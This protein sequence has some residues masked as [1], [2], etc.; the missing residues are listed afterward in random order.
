MGFEEY[1]EG[2][3]DVH[4]WARKAKG[5][6]AHPRNARYFSTDATLLPA[7]QKG[8]ILDAFDAASRAEINLWEQANRVPL[9][10]PENPGAG[11]EWA[12]CTGEQLILAWVA[13]KYTSADMLKD[14]QMLQTCNMTKPFKNFI[15]ELQIKMLKCGTE[16]K[17]MIDV[18]IRAAP[19]RLPAAF[20]EGRE[21]LQEHLINAQLKGL[22]T[23]VP[24]LLKTAV[25]YEQELQLKAE[26]LGLP[27]Y[28]VPNEHRMGM[29][30]EV[31]AVTQG[32]DGPDTLTMGHI[33]KLIAKTVEETVDKK[34]AASEEKL[35]TRLTQVE[36]KL[37][38]NISDMMEVLMDVRSNLK[39]P[40][41]L[42]LTAP[43]GPAAYAPHQRRQAAPS[44]TC[45]RCGERGHWSSQCRAEN[46]RTI[47][48]AQQSAP[49]RFSQQP[50]GRQHPVN[51][52]QVALTGLEC[53]NCGCRD[54][55]ARFCPRPV[56][57]ELASALVNYL[58]Y[59]D[60][61]SRGSGI[62]DAI[63]EQ[64][65]ECTEVAQE[66]LVNALNS[67]VIGPDNLPV[68]DD[69]KIG[70][71]PRK[72][73]REWE[74]LS[75][76][77]LQSGESPEHCSHDRPDLTQ[78]MHQIEDAIVNRRR[79]A[80]MNQSRQHCF[81]SEFSR[82]DPVLAVQIQQSR[83]DAAITRAL[84]SSP[85]P[86][87][88]VILK[89]GSPVVKTVSQVARVQVAA[90]ESQATGQAECR[91]AYDDFHDIIDLSETLNDELYNVVEY[92]LTGCVE[93]T[94]HD[95][96]DLYGILNEEFEH[97]INDD[98]DDDDEIIN[99]SVLDNDDDNDDEIINESILIS[100]TKPG[101]LPVEYTGAPTQG[102]VSD[103]PPDRL[104]HPET[105]RSCHTAGRQ[106]QSA[107]S[108]SKHVGVVTGLPRLGSGSLEF[109]RQARSE[110]SSLGPTGQ[111][112]MAYATG[113]A[114]D[115]DRSTLAF[116]DCVAGLTST[117]HSDG[118]M[119]DSESRALELLGCG[120]LVADGGFGEATDEA[121]DSHSDQPRTLSGVDNIAKIHD[122][123]LN[124]ISN[125][126]PEDLVSVTVIS[127][128]DRNECS[129]E[130]NTSI[131]DVWF[132]IEDY[133][134]WSRGV[135]SEPHG[136]ST[137]PALLEQPTQTRPRRNERW[138]NQGL[139]CHQQSVDSNGNLIRQCKRSQSVNDWFATRPGR[140]TIRGIG[141]GRASRGLSMPTVCG[142]EQSVKLLARLPGVTRKVFRLSGWT[143]EI[144]CRYDDV[145]PAVAAAL[146]IVMGWAVSAMALAAV[147]QFMNRRSAM[148]RIALVAV[149]AIAS[150]AIGIDSILAIDGW[151][152]LN[153]IP[154]MV[155][156]GFT[157]IMAIGAQWVLLLGRELRDWCTARRECYIAQ[158]RDFHAL[159]VEV[160]VLDDKNGVE[161]VVTAV[162]DTG[163]SVTIIPTGYIART[164]SRVGLLPHAP[165]PPVM[166][167]ASGD[168]L[169]D[170]PGA[171]H[172]R[173]R[174]KGCDKVFDCEPWVASNQSVP[175]LLGIDWL[176]ESGAVIDTKRSTMTIDG[177]V[178]PLKAEC[179]TRH[180]VNMTGPVNNVGTDTDSCDSQCY[181][182]R[183]QKDVTVKPGSFAQIRLDINTPVAQLNCLQTMLVESCVDTTIPVLPPDHIEDSEQYEMP[184]DEMPE[185][186]LAHPRLNVGSDVAYIVT[187]V[188]NVTDKPMVIRKGQ[189]LAES[190]TVDPEYIAHMGQGATKQDM[191]NAQSWVNEPTALDAEDWR[192]ACIDYKQIIEKVRLDS[193]PQADRWIE[194]QS[195]TMKFGDDA[196][197]W[198][199]DQFPYLLY[200]FREIAATNAK[201][202]LALVGVQHEFVFTTEPKPYKMK[203]RRRS[204]AQEKAEK[205]QTIIL[206]KNQMI[207]PAVSPFAAEIVLTPK[208][209]GTL[210]YAVDFRMLNE[211]TE[212]D[213]MPL[214][215]PDDVLDRI[216]IA[217]GLAAASANKKGKTDSP[218]VL[219][220][221]FDCASAFWSCIIRECDR[222]YTAF[223]TSLGLMEWIRMPFG[224]KNSMSTY[225]RAMQY[226]LRPPLFPADSAGDVES[227]TKAGERVDVLCETYVDDCT[228]VAETGDAEWSEHMAALCTVFKRF[229]KYKVSI[230]LSKSLWGTTELVMVGYKYI[231]G[232]GIATSDEKIAA[233]MAMEHPR[234]VGEIKTF[235][236]KTGYYRRFIQ[237][238]AAIARPMKQLEVRYKTPTTN[239]E[240]EWVADP[241]YQRSFEAIRSAMANAP[242][243]RSPDFTKPFMV[244][245][246]CSAYAMGA[247]LCQLDEE[248]VEH[249]VCYASCTLS[250]AQVKYGITDREG[251]AVT[252][253][254]RLWRHYL[255][256]NQGGAVVLTD[257]SA[258]TSLM[259]KSDFTNQRMARYAVDLS[260]FDLTICH[261]AG[262]IHHAPDAL[263]R[264]KMCTDPVEIKRRVIEAWN[265][266]TDMALY[267]DL[268]LGSAGEHFQDSL[269]YNR[270]VS[271]AQLAMQVNQAVIE[272]DEVPEG[273]T[274]VRQVLVALE[275][276]KSQLRTPIVDEFGSHAASMYD[277]IL[278]VETEQPGLDK[279]T[280]TQIKQEQKGD[281]WCRHMY[282]YLSQQ[283]L[284]I[285][286]LEAGSISAAA[287]HYIIEPG[288]KVIMRHDPMTAEAALLPASIANN[289]DHIY[290]PPSLRSTVIEYMHTISP[291]GHAKGTKLCRLCAF[292]YW[293]PNMSADIRK[294]VT[295]CGV[296]NHQGDRHKKAPIQGHL[297]ATRPRQKWV[298]DLVFLPKV[299]GGRYCLTAV[300]VFSRWGITIPIQNKLSMT[301]MKQLYDKI[302][303]TYGPFEC[304]VS[305]QGSEFKGTVEEMLKISGIKH[306]VSA[307]HHSESHGM[308]E[309]YNKSFVK[310]LSQYVS[311]DGS[312][313][314]LMVGR[315]VLA[316]N[317]SPHTALG[318][319]TPANVFLGNDFVFNTPL[320]DDGLAVSEYVQQLG[321][322]F[323]K[324]KLY[325][326]KEQSRYYADMEK[327][328]LGQSGVKA[329]PRSFKIAD[330]VMRWKTTGSKTKDKLLGIKEGPYRVVGYGETAVDFIVQQ[331]GT[332]KQPVHVHVDDLS[333]FI[334]KTV[335]KAAGSLDPAE[336]NATKFEVE[337]VIGERDSPDGK[338]YEIKWVSH[339]DTTWEP[340]SN[341]HFKGSTRSSPMGRWN[342]M[343]AID[344]N[345]LK[346]RYSTQVS[347][348]FSCQVVADLSKLS[349][350]NM[351]KLICEI[352]GVDPEDVALVWCSP[353]CTTYSRMNRVNSGRITET[354]PC[355]CGYRNFDTDHHD[356]CCG[357]ESCKYSSLAREHD[358]LITRVIQALMSDHERG[359][360]YEIA[361]ENPMGSLRHRIDTLSNSS[362]KSLVKRKTIDYC[363][364][365]HEYQKRTDI[366][367]TLDTWLPKGTTGSGMCEQKCGHG[368]VQLKYAHF[369]NM[370][371]V[372]GPG[373][374]ARK[375]AVPSMLLTEIL[376]QVKE[377][378]PNKTVVIDLF[379]GYQSMR[380]PAESMGYDYIAVDLKDYSHLIC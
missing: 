69:C 199:R 350:A 245:T 248:G 338:E 217:A 11:V 346:V 146:C 307:A 367:T 116:Y 343:N 246:D 90:P 55:N 87:T 222:K 370:Y 74:R 240:R 130:Y 118:S 36:T 374:G 135:E 187:V 165:A 200:A 266:S 247:V 228:V 50:R 195:D 62:N 99:E 109:G 143:R 166:R 71:K 241:V 290:L 179:G 255:H 169:G 215:R 117:D 65:W 177:S 353:P 91:V 257:H 151:S 288:F 213:S 158:Y 94:F 120:E 17:D 289:T 296:C 278:N 72:V 56:K 315:A 341:L 231:A 335:S 185:Y 160:E 134:S 75:H 127:E 379:S 368:S 362:W 271:A 352:A 287:P 102:L 27:T 214:P 12:V 168:G 103:S 190:R 176:T 331:C 96:V 339:E 184:V 52:T 313:W 97:I 137:V 33:N 310:M 26:M 78:K 328:R 210:R 227:G 378:Q 347:S 280:V 276:I 53:I 358:N 344:R 82:S 9:P 372:T 138:L 268:E 147:A 316:H 274:T 205:E 174:F 171:T 357:N 197:Q 121:G 157:H 182:L 113:I 194:S 238:Y 361:M 198:F 192:E 20:K 252:W 351:I 88:V 173:F 23:D 77:Y 42:A 306:V 106:S 366:F 377:T 1:V 235:L 139:G 261:R 6:L 373:K 21:S 324:V 256:G 15:H 299:D 226:I 293:W 295:Q 48:A 303:L 186:F 181:M 371:N 239:I 41:P 89:K 8:F 86:D 291:G 209:D 253:A 188:N 333:Q 244:L 208:H 22:I 283:I 243:L 284:P 219:I 314:P 180:G 84:R 49:P 202:P 140:K 264:F 133:D 29:R 45:H 67:G 218:Q 161:T 254:V 172:V 263:S 98:D 230:K 334:G 73:R 365:D 359:I 175:F 301:V 2:L 3:T 305:D 136:T 145:M 141:A 330:L 318:G 211:V 34:I 183:A 101:R 59:D 309:R 47:P 229:A 216:G 323:D 304:L 14:K 319:L 265:C 234:T 212:A 220:S 93:E 156:I 152:L 35:E 332:T 206:L 363:A 112:G 110:R 275:N 25:E 32:C 281:R 282:E 31:M 81:L 128:I 178:I 7:Q 322:E 115:S 286:T 122:Q 144:A 273:C 232:K 18:V 57:K 155:T 269:L 298:V 327:S 258:L 277:M 204:P 28:I 124:L 108:S 83:Q 302:L 224:L 125:T 131:K 58:S 375:N 337:L 162:I 242:V 189:L 193:K 5:E 100:I 39:A 149:A 308:I 196:P 311:A 153:A 164:L 355:G 43:S 297:T 13:C 70:K 37:G 203:R 349:P 233:L 340:V 60:N 123:V 30:K 51:S 10:T 46:D 364:Y 95:T 132:E 312:D 201:A 38:K 262:A 191:N 260:E 66:Y 236:G 61:L 272:S 63:I 16:M 79:L 24:S 119:T 221:T 142:V 64:Q 329:I 285:D 76:L 300:D 294:W 150:S 207:Q 167:A 321:I 317:G 369:Q 342:A 348:I 111:G 237:N 104:C 19:A 40:T 356:P 354:A 336:P 360:E 170:I 325:I 249:P 225:S 4:A 250:E 129:D 326:E 159:I 320:V 148:I 380:S 376:E 270:G 345:K 267:T 107:P 54:H 85:E 259:K 105:S 92:E 292:Y 251:L 163:S 126:A 223:N 154:W 80:R 44:D 279:L 114:D 68:I